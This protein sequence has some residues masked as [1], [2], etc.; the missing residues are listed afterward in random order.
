MPRQPIHSTK[1]ARRPR[2][3]CAGTHRSSSAMQCCPH[4]DGSLCA[5]RFCG[6]SVSWDAVPDIGSAAAL[7]TEMA[8]RYVISNCP[9]SLHCSFNVQVIDSF[10]FLW[11]CFDLQC[12][13]F[14][15]YCFALLCFVCFAL[16]C[17]A[18]L[19]F[20]LH[21]LVLLCFA[22]ICLHCF[23]LLCFDLLCF[24]LCCFALLRT[25]LLC[26]ALHCFNLLCC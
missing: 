2:S 26:F 4:G 25:A 5:S 19:R 15:C 21:C 14:P 22:L 12:F 18:L 8:S 24:A 3:T 1:A 6:A 7:L 20:A 17:C 10:P 13:A 23:N 9:C 16:L 11:Y